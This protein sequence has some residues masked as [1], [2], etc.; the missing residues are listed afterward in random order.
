[1]DDPWRGRKNVAARDVVLRFI[2]AIN[3]HAV[4]DIAA[5][6]PE[7]RWNTP[8]AWRAVTEHGRLAVWQVS[9]DDEP[10]RRAMPAREASPRQPR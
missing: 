9:A 10:I 6:L 2:D 3:R 5:L 8:A 7:D 1:M 4:D